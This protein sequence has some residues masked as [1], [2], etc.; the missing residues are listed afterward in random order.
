VAALGPLRADL[1]SGD[2]RA[3]YLLWLTVVEA[4]IFTD[5]TL[6]PLPG[7]GPLS[8]ALEAFGNFF[9]I[10]PN[11]VQAAAE[12]SADAADPAVATAAANAAMA[13]IPEVEKTALLL[14]LAE[15]D[16]H[17]AAEIKGLVRASVNRSDGVDDPSRA[18]G[19]TVRELLS[20]AEAIQ[21]EGER[22]RK[23]RREAERRKQVEADE[24]L[25]RTRLVALRRRGTGVWDEIEA[26]IERRNAVGYDRAA[27]FLF[28]LGA[29]AE[30]DGTMEAFSNRLRSLRE[31]HQRKGRFI[32]RLTGLDSGT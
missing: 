21:A 9:N 11:L 1:L 6:E 28:D 25:R 26:E 18:R 13:A 3:L 19:R 30:Q 15:G 31:R 8:G 7:I 22:L 16:P 14:R 29:L 2:L 4:G 10:D 5:D 24:M 23:E 27:A 32:E 12:R 20:R 17:V